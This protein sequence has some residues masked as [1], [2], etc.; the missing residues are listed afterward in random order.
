MN[1]RP[2][3]ETDEAQFGTGQVSVDFAR[4]LESER[5]E[6]RFDLEFR[7]R[8]GDWQN[9]TIDEL[10][11]ARDEAREQRDRLAVVLQS[12]RDCYGGQVADPDCQCEDCEFLIPIDKALQSLTTNADVMA[13]PPEPK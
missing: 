10:T 5:D 4:R 8:L 1:T 6:A 9:K 13:S 2:T 3:P 7:R 12:I 11:H